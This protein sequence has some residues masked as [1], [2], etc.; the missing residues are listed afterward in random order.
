MEGATTL[1]PGTWEEA[2]AMVG[3]TIAHLEGADPVSAADIRR[4][5]EVLGFDSPLHTDPAWARDHGHPDVVSPAS[6]AR[7]WAMPAYWTPGEPRPGTSPMTT[8]IAATAVPGE[9]DTMIATRIRTR[10]LAPMYPGD[11]ISATS[12]LAA[13]TRKTTRVGDG[14]FI[15][16]E[17]T[18][19]NQ[20]G[21]PVA[22]ETSSLFRY[23]GGGS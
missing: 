4:K 20:R 18:Y 23:H 5:L 21:E 9:G 12:V 19:R 8:P 15:T 17:T 16:I 13:V 7:V 22:I 11:R 3:R 14:A 6:M 1:A 2:E 10:H